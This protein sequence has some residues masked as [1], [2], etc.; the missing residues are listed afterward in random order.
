MEDPIPAGALPVIGQDLQYWD[1]TADFGGMI[2][3]RMVAAPWHHGCRFADHID[4]F[5][6]VGTWLNHDTVCD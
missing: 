3:H 4:F 1:W 6:R 2:Y 5:P